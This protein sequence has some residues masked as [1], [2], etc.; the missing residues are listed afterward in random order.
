MGYFDNFSKTRRQGVDIAA[1]T[2]ISQVAVRASYSYLDA[3][4]QD[5]G[6]LFGGEREIDVVP[7]TK[8][9]GLPQH[10][11][12]LGADWRASDKLT[13]G[14]TVIGT[15][16]IVTQG[17]EDGKIEDDVTYDAKIKGYQ[18]LNLHANYE[19]QKGLDYFARINNVFDTRF[20]TY[21]MMALSMFNAN[22]G[23]IDD[24]GVP[25]TTG[26][27]V[28]RFVAPGAPRHLMIGLRY[29]F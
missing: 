25:T 3:T 24:S 15:S 4:Y 6:E 23:L 13:I 11:F 29:R 27:N 18:L 8:I 17:N 16:S 26:P 5:S 1:Y 28:S 7:G 10:T 19:A 20:E 9:A 14:G 22:G 12:K 2:S 21:G